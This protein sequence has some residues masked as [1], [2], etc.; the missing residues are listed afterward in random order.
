MRILIIDLILILLQKQILKVKLKIKIALNKKKLVK[1]NFIKV[2]KQKI[3]LIKILFN[4][5]IGI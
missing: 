1:L 3:Y 2:T 4:N 5:I